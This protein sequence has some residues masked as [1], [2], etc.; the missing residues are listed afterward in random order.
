MNRRPA[1][2]PSA[3]HTLRAEVISRPGGLGDDSY[4]A[5]AID[6]PG[7]DSPYVLTLA[8]PTVVYQALSEQMNPRAFYEAM[9]CAVN[10]MNADTT[11][12]AY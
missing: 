3:I 5:L 1:P 4:P 2:A 6:L 7:F 11:A 9:A 8:L 12:D 10:R